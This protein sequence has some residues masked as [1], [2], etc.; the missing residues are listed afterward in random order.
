[1]S[2][3]SFRFLVLEVGTTLL[4][5]AL[6][7]IWTSD[8]RSVAIAPL[9][10]ILSQFKR[11]WLFSRVGSDL[12]PSL[13]RLVGGYAIAVIF[14][15]TVGFLLGLYRPVRI[16]ALPIV[17]FMR[18]LPP[19]TLLPIGIILLGAGDVMAITIIGFA[20]CWPVLLNTMDGVAEQDTTMLDT[21]RLYGIS[22]LDRLRFVIFPAVLPR[23]IT[24]MRTSLS[25]AI[26]T[27]VAAEF[28]GATSG[29]GFAIYSAQLAYAPTKMW[30]SVLM[31]GILGYALN[32]GFGKVER[33][34]LHWH[35]N[36][37]TSVS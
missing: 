25:L 36:A 27:L 31:L 2:A 3:R 26:L 17:T 15:A 8:S 11:E 4:I 9:P 37:Y 28:L 24:G 16:A 10:D 30:S 14:G 1:M 33:R 35:I 19:I 6:V 20:T 21:A 12:L 32:F 18:S 22:G 23:L 5:V 34:I 13:K 29:V 7:W